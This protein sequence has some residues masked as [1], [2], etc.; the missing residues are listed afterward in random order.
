MIFSPKDYRVKKVKK[1]FSMWR[2]W[3]FYD[4]YRKWTKLWTLTKSRTPFWGLDFS[5]PSGQ[6]SWKTFKN[7]NSFLSYTDTFFSIK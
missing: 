2:S 1:K 5:F 4:V 6:Y 3:T 7:K